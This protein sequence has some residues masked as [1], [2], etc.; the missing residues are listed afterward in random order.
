MSKKRALEG[1]SEEGRKA[2]RV[3]EKEEEE[4]EEEEELSSSEQEDEEDSESDDDL[5]LEKQADEELVN[6]SFDF[7]DMK[8]EYSDGVSRMLHHLYDNE[9]DALEVA[10]VITQQDIVGTAVCSEG[11]SDVFAYATILPITSTKECKNIGDILSDLLESCKKLSNGEN[12]DAII[13]HINGEKSKST[14]LFLHG[15]Y[16]NLPLQLSV[17][18]HS[19]LVDDLNW[20]K[21]ESDDEGA[22]PFKGKG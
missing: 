4:E 18:L 1:E 8:E 10:N 11:E 9:P 19:N 2:L 20:A 17:A 21:D 3:K 13:D 7:N 22:I 5:L 6:M 15:R 14:G 12:K 16:M